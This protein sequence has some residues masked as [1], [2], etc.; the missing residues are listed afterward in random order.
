M[1]I[2]SNSIRTMGYLSYSTLRHGLS[3]RP[4]LR[5][6]RQRQSDVFVDNVGLDALTPLWE[7]GKMLFQTTAGQQAN[8]HSG[9]KQQRQRPG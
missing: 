9:E 7:A 3:S 4:L 5:P 1:T 8:L 2:S 6:D